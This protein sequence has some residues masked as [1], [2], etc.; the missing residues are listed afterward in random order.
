MNKEIYEIISGHSAKTGSDDYGG[1]RPAAL[2]AANETV[3]KD[4]LDDDMIEAVRRLV[5]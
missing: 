5:G 3:C 4:L 2:M 1:E